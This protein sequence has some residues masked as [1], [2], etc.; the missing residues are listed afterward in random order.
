MGVSIKE[1]ARLT[2]VSRGTVDRALNDRAGIDP[3]VKEKVLKVATEQG[4]RSNKAGRILGLRKKPL[5]IGV[6]MPSEGNDFF[7]DVRA[8]LE[9]AVAARADF[10][11]SM[12]LRTMKGFDPTLQVRQVRDLLAEGIQALALVPISHPDILAL[13][14]ELHER[15]LPV[16]TVNT[17]IVGG[18]RLGYVGTDYLSSG[19]AAGGVLRLLAD[20]RP[21]RV[22]VLTGSFRML[23][24]NQRVEGFRRALE[25]SAPGLSILGVEKT[26]DDDG[27]AY[28]KLSAAL[29]RTPAPEAVYVA[30][31]GVAG[32]CR[33]IEEHGVAGIGPGRVRII[34][35]DLT[36][37]IRD[38]LERGVLTATIGQQP[39]EQGYQAI[40]LLFDHHVDGTLPP[41]RTLTHNEIV[42][43]ENL[44]GGTP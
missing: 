11:V 30:A 2:G 9:R 17:D 14:E 21:L 26:E 13:L 4:Y 41:D 6:Q 3:A 31:G 15:H 12:A 40:R 16:L 10:G 33:A 19:L 23:G 18:K 32:A 39:F 44:K 35:N 5:R 36:P 8:G 37:A 27:I 43:A 24:H 20:G 25:S 7:L 1:I 34:G 42:I 28:G 29:D 22:L 38:Y